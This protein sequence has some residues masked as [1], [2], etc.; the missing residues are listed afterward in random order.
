MWRAALAIVLG[1]RLA[2]AVLAHTVFAQYP[3]PAGPGQP[4]SHDSM[5]S[6]GA[7]M[8]A[9]HMRAMRGMAGGRTDNARA[10]CVRRDRG[11]RPDPRSRSG[12]RLEQGRYRAPPPASHRH[13]RGRAALG[14]QADAG[15]RGPRH[16]DHRHGAD[17]AGH[18]RDGGSARCRAGPYA[19]V[20]SEDRDHPG[21]RAADRLTKK[22]DDAKVV[23]RIRGLG[24]AGLI[25][26]GAHHQPHHLAMAKGE[27]LAGHTR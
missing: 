7:D 8:H 17:R 14:G 5:P 2:G 11:D 23:A 6:H 18:S 21:R 26:E 16:G 27:A 22:P 12:H 24:F 4:H 9:E 15:P 10:G 20:V 3:P 19:G 13:E 25:T 1:R